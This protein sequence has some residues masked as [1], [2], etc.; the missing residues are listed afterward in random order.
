MALSAALGSR[1]IGRGTDSASAPHR[2]MGSAGAALPL[3]LL[4]LG[5]SEVS[6]L[7]GAPAAAPALERGSVSGCG[8]CP[9]P[10]RRGRQGAGQRGSL[11]VLGRQRAWLRRRVEG[12]TSAA[13]LKQP[14][15]TPGFA[16]SSFAFP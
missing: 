9:S 13:F 16:W 7:R 6:A 10:R 3:L 15:R 1:Q 5:R 11:R 4:A 12:G 2:A 14:K 8:R